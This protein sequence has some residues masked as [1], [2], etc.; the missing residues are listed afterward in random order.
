MKWRKKGKQAELTTFRIG[1]CTCNERDY[2][3]FVC[4]SEGLNSVT[5][6][7]PSSFLGTQ[8]SFHWAQKK[9]LTLFLS[10]TGPNNA[11]CLWAEAAIY[12]LTPFVETFSEC[13]PCSWTYGFRQNLG[14]WVPECQREHCLTTIIAWSPRGPS[15]QPESLVSL[16]LKLFCNL[17]LGQILQTTWKITGR[18]YSENATNAN[19]N[20]TMKV[21]SLPNFFIAILAHVQEAGK[22]HC[23]LHSP[24]ATGCFLKSE[25]SSVWHPREEVPPGWRAQSTAAPEAARRQRLKLWGRE[26]SEC[27]CSI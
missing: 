23:K 7:I 17:D 20:T 18:A 16:P 11:G 3:M 21:K 19:K 9:H 26:G 14:T 13:Y 1:V 2:I 5:S 25:P 4:R 12:V 27:Q 22:V 15:A 8:I 10:V 6:D 24:S